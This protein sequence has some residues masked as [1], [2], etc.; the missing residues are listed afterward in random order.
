MAVT[1]CRYS[2]YFGNTF[3]SSTTYLINDTQWF[4]LFPS[5]SSFEAY[6]PAQDF[7]LL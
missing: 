4:V 3:F 6:M 1:A 5:A 2:S 7:Y